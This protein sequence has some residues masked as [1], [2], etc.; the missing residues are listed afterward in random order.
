[1]Q[2]ALSAIFLIQWPFIFQSNLFFNEEKSNEQK[3]SFH[4]QFTKCPNCNKRK[5]VRIFKALKNICC[6]MNFSYPLYNAIKRAVKHFFSFYESSYFINLSD[7]LFPFIVFVVLGIIAN[8]LWTVFMEKAIDSKSM[9][10][11]EKE[12][13]VIMYISVIAHFFVFLIVVSSLVSKK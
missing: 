1:M 7:F 12:F 5:V 3:S 10:C 4:K 11:Y 6:I 2:G 13:V 8:F 9:A